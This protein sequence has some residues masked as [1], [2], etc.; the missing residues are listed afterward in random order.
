[1]DCSFGFSAKI[2]DF[3]EA[4]KQSV[5]DISKKLIPDAPFNDTTN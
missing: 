4:G 1:M 2:E 5:K 3:H